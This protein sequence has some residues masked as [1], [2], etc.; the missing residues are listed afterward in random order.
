[1]AEIHGLAGIIISTSFE[2]YEAM[3]RFY[4]ELLG[5]TIRSRRSGFVNFELGVDTRLTVT[6]HDAVTGSSPDPARLMI[7]L[8]VDD[9]DAWA[10]RAAELG[11]HV[12]RHPDDES[13][14][15]RICTI[16]DPDGNY[17]QFMRLP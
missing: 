3:E 4:V 12:I 8:N 14:G 10:R 2:R 1:M 9:V 16:A 11:A 5:R 15:G 13:W 6:L 17:I 7:N